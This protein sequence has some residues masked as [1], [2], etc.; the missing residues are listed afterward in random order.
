MRRRCH[1]MNAYSMDL[2]QSVVAA[3]D[4]GEETREQ[5]ARRFC[6]SIAW[7]YNRRRSR[8]DQAA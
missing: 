4:R 6:V 7:V 8:P 5:V 2:R 3:C 1:T